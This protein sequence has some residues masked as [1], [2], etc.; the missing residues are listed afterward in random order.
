L[1]AES[2]TNPLALNNGNDTPLEKF[3]KY[4]NPLEAVAPFNE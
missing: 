1:L 3:E 2:S 4:C